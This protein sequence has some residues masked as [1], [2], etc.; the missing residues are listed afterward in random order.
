[1]NISS[2]NITDVSYH[3]IGLRVLAESPACRGRSH[4]VELISRSVHKFVYDRALRLMLPEPRGTFE[5]TGKRVCQELVQLGLARSHGGGYQL[6][7]SGSAA[8]RL[9]GSRRYVELRKLMVAAHL[10]TYDNLRAVLQTHLDAGY[11][12]RPIVEA[13]K[14]EHPDYIKKLLEPMFGA[15]AAAEASAMLSGPAAWSSKSFESTLHTKILERVMPDH[16]IRG[17]PVQGN[18]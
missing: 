9:L 6:T 11:I 13:A 15:D 18:V 14:L 3:Y 5:T 2:Y 1:M 4:Q 16:R 12:W 7:D 8:L 10:Q 17:T